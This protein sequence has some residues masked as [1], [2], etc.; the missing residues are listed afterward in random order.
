MRPGPSYNASP[1]AET[2]SSPYGAP[3]FSSL[4]P[5][6]CNAL[7]IV[8]LRFHDLRHEGVSR[9]FEAGYSIEQVALISGHKD[10]KQLQ[11]YTQIKAKNLHR[12]LPTPSPK[13]KRKPRAQVGAVIGFAPL[14]ARPKE[15]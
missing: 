15:A 7:G 14:K 4:F 5:R 9:L 2:S 11:R 12:K 6:A 1:A 8:D 13:A 10:W 3:T